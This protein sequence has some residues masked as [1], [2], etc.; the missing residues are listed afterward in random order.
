MGPVARDPR[1]SSHN[2]SACRCP[3]QPMLYNRHRHLAL[4]FVY[5]YPSTLLWI[6]SLPQLLSVARWTAHQLAT[7]LAPRSQLKV[8]RIS[9]TCVQGVCVQA[10]FALMAQARCESST[11]RRGLCCYSPVVCACRASPPALS[12]R[13][14]ACPPR[15]CDMS[16]VLGHTRQQVA[17]ADWHTPCGTGGLTWHCDSI[18][19]ACTPDSIAA[20]S[21][22]QLHVSYPCACQPLT[23]CIAHAIARVPQLFLS[24]RSRNLVLIR[25]GFTCTNILLFGLVMMLRAVVSTCVACC[26]LSSQRNSRQKSITSCSEHRPTTAAC[27][28]IE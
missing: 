16:G 5:R 4:S 9:D 12:S 15:L 2:D 7:S 27:T 20:Q 1:V 25:V 19:F 13:A 22:R 23:G 8:R 6:S 11:S 28:Q 21:L 26:K 18:A 24:C 17:V 10:L 3:L 14:M